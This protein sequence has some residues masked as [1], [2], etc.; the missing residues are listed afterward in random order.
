MSSATTTSA[1]PTKTSQGNADRAAN[2]LEAISRG[3]RHL[4]A[5]PVLIDSLVAGSLLSTVARTAATASDAGL[6]DAELASRLLEILPEQAAPALGIERAM[7]S[8]VDAVAAEFDRIA[9]GGGTFD[10]SIAEL[11]GAGGDGESGGADRDRTLVQHSS[12]E[13]LHTVLA[14][15]EF[16]I[17]E[18]SVPI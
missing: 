7:R 2:A 3:T 18:V 8:E 9:D 11:F 1:F 17:K 14:Y 15:G 16:C 12:Q 10:P 4:S 5:D 13:G 6:V